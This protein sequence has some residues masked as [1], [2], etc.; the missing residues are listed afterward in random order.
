LLRGDEHSFDNLRY[1]VT[2]EPIAMQVWYFGIETAEPR[3]SLLYYLQRV[4]LETAVQQVSIQ[5]MPAGP[6]T[7]PP[8]PREVPLVIVARAL[9]AA[10]SSILRQYIELGGRVLAVLPDQDSAQGIT[11]AIN[12][13]AASQIE[14]TEAEVDDYV[15]LTRI[16]FASRLFRSMADPQFN[17]FSKIRFWS[18]RR[19]S[20]LDESWRILA[21]FEAGDP[22]F[23][24][25]AIGQGELLVMT[26]GW[27]PQ[28]GQLALSTKFIP[29]VYSL[30]DLSPGDQQI[31]EYTIGETIPFAPS[32][33]AT[34]TSPSGMESA[35]RSASDI[36]AISQPGIYTFRDGDQTRSFAVNLRD[37]ESRTDPLDEG[38]LERFGVVVG[39]PM[40]VKQALEN[41]RQL[42]DRELESQQKLWQWLLVAA[43]GILGVETLLSGLWSRRQPAESIATSV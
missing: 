26:T 34:L 21:R 43:L 28:A 30:L 37:S 6:I 41:Q 13:V 31:N 27:Q 14:V 9:D 39:Q 2:P 3:D 20:N 12:E 5:A 22:A 19:L 11:Q 25:R 32:A 10:D 24:E 1:V 36:D 38:E 7:D 40:S 16:D 17:D 18:H 23:L 42:R 4:P 8:N 33:T 29:L 15:M 35:Y